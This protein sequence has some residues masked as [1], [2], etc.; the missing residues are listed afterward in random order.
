M[1]RKNLTVL[2]LVVLS[3]FFYSSLLAQ[4][5]TTFTAYDGLAN[6][7][8][9]SILEDNNNDIWFGTMGGLGKW[10]FKTDDWTEYTQESSPLVNNKVNAILQDSNGH[11]WFGTNNGLSEFDG[12]NWKDYTYQK[13]PDSLRAEHITSLYLD[14]KN[15]LWIGTKGGGV[16]KR[17]HNNGKWKWEPYHTG[18]SGIISDEITAINED[19][20]GNIWF[21]TLDAGICKFDGLS[22]WKPFQQYGSKINVIFKDQNHQLWFGTS[23]GVFGTYDG[24]NWTSCG[25]V[26]VVRAIAEDREGNLWF[27]TENNGLYEYNRNSCL[28]SQIDGLEYITTIWSIMRDHNGYLWLGT[29]GIGVIRLHLN[30]LKFN[31]ENSDL[32]SNDITS[33]DED[34]NGNLWIGTRSNGI[35]SYDDV[36]F[37]PYNVTDGLNRRNRINSIMVDKDNWIWCATENGAH[38]FN[39]DLSS[40]ISVDYLKNRVVKSVIQDQ[41]GVFWF[42][43]RG[44][45]GRFDGNLWT[46]I[47]TSYGLPDLI[48]NT[49]FEDHLGNIWFGT[50]GGGVCKFTG[51]SIVVVYDTSKGLIDNHVNAIIQDKDFNYWF[52]TTKGISRFDGDNS[53]DSL[54][55]ENSGLPHNNVTCLLKDEKDNILSG[56]YGGGLSKYDGQFWVNFGLQKLGSDEINDI[57]QDTNG[58]LW[59]G[60]L[61]GL[62]KCIPDRMPPETII[63]HKPD[64]IIDDSYALFIFKGIDTETPAEK[65]VYSWALKDDQSRYVKNWSS[66]SKAYYCNVD[67]SNGNYTFLVK[68]KDEFGNEDPTPASFKFT[69]DTTPPTTI[70]HYPT[71]QEIISGKVHIIGT[72]CDTSLA[73]E[74]KKYWVDYAEVGSNEDNWTIINDTLSS[75]VINDTLIV[76]DCTLYGS[77]YIKLSAED[78]K[79][80][81][82]DYTVQVHVVE[83]LREVSKD[84]GSFLQCSQNHAQLFI[85]PWAL[86][87]D[88][89][90]YFSPVNPSQIPSSQNERITFSAIA[91]FIGPDSVQLQKP[92]TLTCYYSD[93]DIAALYESKLA[94][95]HHDN[96]ELV[97]GFIDAEENKISTTIKKFGTYILIENDSTKLGHHAI[98][99]LDCQ[100]R[101]F[102][103]KGTGIH[104][105]TNISFNLTTDSEVSIKIYN[106]AGR[107]VR[108]LLENE[109]LRADNKSI[110]WDGRD[111]NGNICPSDLYIVTIESAKK[112][113]TKTVMILDKS[114][115]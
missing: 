109:H 66:Y 17:Y 8:V 84:K 39:G 31:K 42:A 107:L 74:F 21:G 114:H 32:A 40:W 92:A 67:L 4:L 99:D 54:T 15:N 23:N 83:T 14:T 33:I 16:A 108:V 71:D 101:I 49:I 68:T 18:N 59:F 29:D 113:K 100:P 53:W 90:I 95:M 76:W 26:P 50:S 79:G 47:D 12:E 24:S 45:V 105:T 86:K 70:I 115:N 6:N 60:T 22:H 13:M 88:T 43:T 7:T 30:W 89:E 65:L 87:K 72:A 98:Y 11:F 110:E 91:Y 64:S 10:I 82:N 1:K 61:K 104:A 85:S 5:T 112:V 73:S 41:K 37:Y 106:L 58:N 27:G 25:S 28:K 51:D 19:S 75:P 57:F 35:A 69:V 34:K 103:P 93:S 80:R 97:G 20:S 62:V 55:K 77:Y 44:G 78:I 52:A 94:L 111:Y 36:L 63:I 38:R 46:A 102:S 48:V 2:G 81:K 56:T 3:F 9:F 96:L